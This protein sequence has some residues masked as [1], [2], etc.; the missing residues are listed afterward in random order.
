MEVTRWATGSWRD[1]WGS[2]SWRHYASERRFLEFLMHSSGVGVVE[3][4]VVSIPP[5]GS[6]LCR[7]VEVS[8]RLLPLSNR[9][10]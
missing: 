1:L 9:S 2:M 3:E 4:K 7:P 6:V 8:S 5:S 10:C